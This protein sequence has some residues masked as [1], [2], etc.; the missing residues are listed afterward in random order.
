MKL[1]SKKGLKILFSK[2][3]IFL[4]AVFILPLVIIL[5]NSLNI[6]LDASGEL[7]SYLRYGE[8]DI[9]KFSAEE[10]EHLVEVKYFIQNILVVFV[11][12]IVLFI[13]GLI[14]F[15]IEN[16]SKLFSKYLFFGGGLTLIVLFVVY[17][18]TKN[19]DSAF[20][21]FHQL[22]FKT[23]WQFPEDSLLIT[24]F[25]EQVFY[26][27]FRKIFFNGL[28][29]SVGLVIIGLLIRIRRLRL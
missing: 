23:Q 13:A 16:N 21:N 22:F 1:Y 20:V 4:I 15:L 6:S 8:G 11:I 18:L 19:W 10:Q 24:M 5:G 2:K 14:F 29:S 12:A 26:N 17:L 7:S 28:L 27:A 9:S 25:P 3:I